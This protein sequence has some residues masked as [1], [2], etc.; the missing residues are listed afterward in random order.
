MNGVHQNVSR[1]SSSSSNEPPNYWSPSESA[2]LDSLNDTKP[3]QTSIL[4]QNA[5]QQAAFEPAPETP[6]PLSVNIKTEIENDCG[7]N[8]HPIDMTPPDPAP[9][10]PLSLRPGTSR[11]SGANQFEA[12]NSSKSKVHKEVNNFSRVTTANELHNGDD[13]KK[14]GAFV[15]ETLKRLSKRNPKI[16][17]RAKINIK[18]ILLRAKVTGIDTDHDYA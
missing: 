9:A 16:A 12:K 14:F 8:S 6:I 15:A 5:R 17:K 3:F 10:M 7:E 2:F 1:T 13:H 18:E 11:S 4:L